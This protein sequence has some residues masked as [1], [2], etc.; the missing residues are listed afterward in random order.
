MSCSGEITVSTI[1][2]C[3]NVWDNLQAKLVAVDVAAER[4]TYVEAHQLNVDVAKWK[5]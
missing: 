5:R 1:S 3:Q 2:K 4:K